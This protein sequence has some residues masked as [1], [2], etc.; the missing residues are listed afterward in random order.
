MIKIFIIKNTNGVDNGTKN[1]KISRIFRLS[2]L[3]YLKKTEIYNRKISIPKNAGGFPCYRYGT[4]T[5]NGT[6]NRKVPTILNITKILK[7]RKISKLKNS[8]VFSV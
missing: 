5:G 8:T 7:Y 3:I 6:K 4:K 2:I 1:R